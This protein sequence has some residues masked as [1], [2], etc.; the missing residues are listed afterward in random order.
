VKVKINRRLGQ[1]KSGTVLDLST[2]EAQWLVGRRLATHVP[3]PVGA[4][5]PD[6]TDDEADSDPLPNATLAELKAKADELGVASY[7]SKAHIMERII[8]HGRDLR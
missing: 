8:Q 1:N 6:E 7:G 4:P 3:D 2:D 5:V